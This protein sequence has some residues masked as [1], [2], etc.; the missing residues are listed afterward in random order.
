MIRRFLA[1]LLAIPRNVS[2]LATWAINPKN[3]SNYVTP[4][5]RRYLSTGTSLVVTILYRTGAGLYNFVTS[6]V[7]G[8]LVYIFQ[9]ATGVVLD[10]WRANPSYSRW[11]FRG[12]CSGVVLVATYA[13]LVARMASRVG[14]AVLMGIVGLFR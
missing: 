2:K 11:V 12:V 9:V 8:S 14:Y 1:V 5:N 4:F 13:V 3:G 10:L 7:L 6:Y